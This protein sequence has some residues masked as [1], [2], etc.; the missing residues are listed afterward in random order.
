MRIWKLTCI[1]LAALIWATNS[2]WAGLE[3]CNNTDF[4]QSVAVGYKDGEQWISHGWWN[5]KPGTCGAPV[6]GDLKQRYYYVYGETR[7]RNFAPEP[8][9]SFCTE[10]VAFTIIGDEDCDLR[11]YD[12]KAFARVDTG[13]TAKQFS[14][15]ITEDFYGAERPQSLSGAGSGTD[16]GTG[17]DADSS[18]ANSAAV[19]AQY[20]LPLRHAYEPSGYFGE[21]YAQ[22][23]IFQGC[24]VGEQDGWCAFHAQGWKFYARYG[25]GTTD[26]LLDALMELPIGTPVGFDGDMIEYG[27]NS[28]DVVLREVSYYP[29][30]DTYQ[31]IREAMQGYWR[32]QDDPSV[33]IYIEGAELIEDYG[34]DHMATLWLQI[35]P[36]CEDVPSGPVLLQAYPEDVEPYCYAIKKATPDE[37]ILYDYSNAEAFVYRR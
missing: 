25:H 29:G 16:D 8:R 13:K 1:N 7:D 24:E 11:G 14:L 2:A 34:G 26:E 21:P 6:K 18:T 12:S 28:A 36:S 4:S 15:S 5:L 32:A 31:E 37:L 27:E 33:E 17:G 9:Y 23:G 3:I 22:N 20:I 30:Y 10:S 35:K 19:Q